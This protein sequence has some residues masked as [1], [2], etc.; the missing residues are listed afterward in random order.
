LQRDNIVVE[1]QRR[2][3]LITTANGHGFD[4]QYV[5]RNPEEEP[6]PDLMP[7]TNIFEFP[8]ITLESAPSRGATSKPIYK[9]E[10]RVILESWYKSTS[11]G[12]TSRDVM[13]YLKSTREVIFSDGQTLGRRADLVME[14]EVSR[15]YR[16]DIDNKVVGIGQVLLIHFKEDFNNL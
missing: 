16:P 15:V 10:F 9:Q 1:I 2:V 8:S 12:K 5:F 11:R 3:N 13:Q 14:E 4:I 7:M 6:S